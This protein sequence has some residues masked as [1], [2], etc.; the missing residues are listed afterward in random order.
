MKYL[1]TYETLSSRKYKIDDIL[2]QSKFMKDLSLCDSS[3]KKHKLIYHSSETE[4][5]MDDI[6]EHDFT[7]IEQR[8]RDRPKDLNI[9]LHSYVGDLF[10]DKFGWNPR[11]EAIFCHNGDLEDKREYGSPYIIVPIGDYKYVWNT[12]INDL[13]LYLWYK[14][15]KYISNFYADVRTL[16]DFLN[17]NPNDVTKEKILEIYKECK[18]YVETCTDT[19]LCE[20]LKHPYEIMIKADSYYLISMNYEKYI[21]NRINEIY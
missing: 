6:Q 2:K 5:I 9:G 7:K 17:E 11:K 16:L 18:H 4:Y 15:Q 12:E 21:V 8:D 14:R 10:I 3:F 1:R 20:Y 13:Y 19:N